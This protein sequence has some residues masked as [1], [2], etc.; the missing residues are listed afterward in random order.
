VTTFPRSAP[1]DGSA[2][3]VFSAGVRV[4]GGAEDGRGERHAVTLGGVRRLR[5][6]NQRRHADQR[7]PGG[8]YPKISHG[9]TLEPIAHHR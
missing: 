4:V 2:P 8:P 1:I 6:G 3:G 9:P 7:R 5:R